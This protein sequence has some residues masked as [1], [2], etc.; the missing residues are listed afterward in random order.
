MRL[1]MGVAHDCGS[2]H[3]EWPWREEYMP[4]AVVWRGEWP[5]GVA[6]GAPGGWHGKWPQCREHPL[7]DAVMVWG[8]APG[9][10]TGREGGMGRWR[11]CRAWHREQPWQRELHGLRCSSRVWQRA[12]RGCDT[13]GGVA[14]G[15]RVLCG[16]QVWG[17]VPH[18][19]VMCYSR[20]VL[21]THP[22]RSPCST[23]QPCATPPPTCPAPCSL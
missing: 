5:Q 1:H 21:S 7:A 18:P 13:W 19:M 8:A 15:R 14:R 3:R 10:G 20:W 11:I 16:E 6:Q 2:W 9:C 12:C 23:L 17:C 22:A 4:A